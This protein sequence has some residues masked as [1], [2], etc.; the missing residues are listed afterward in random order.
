MI[1]HHAVAPAMAVSCLA[2]LLGCSTHDILTVTDPDVIPTV[3]S[4]SGA[5]ALKNGVILRLEQATNGIQG[6]D[7]LFVYGGLLADEYRSGDT[8][9]Q[10]NDMDQRRFDPTNT[11]LAGPFRALNRIRVEGAAAIQGLR[12]FAPSPQSNIGLMFAL[13]AYSINLAGE[14]YCNGVPLSSLEGTTIVYGDPLPVDSLFALATGFADSALANQPGPDSAR[15]R[16]LASV[17]KG[18]ALL[19]RARYTAAAAAVAGVRDTFHYDVTYSANTSDNQIWALNTS[20]KR[21]F[22]GD[23][24]GGT[25]LPFYS[26]NDPRVIRSKGGKVF[27]SSLPDT[28]ILQGIWGRFSSVPIATGIEARLIEAEASL[29]AGNSGAWLTTLNAL[30]ANTGLYPTAQTGFT[31]APIPL[32]ALADPGTPD[33]RVDLM[34]YERGFWTFSTGHRL[35]DLRRLIRQ[36]GRAPDSVFPTGTYF[37]GGPYGPAVNMPIPLDEQNNPHF[38]Q[39]TNTSA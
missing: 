20:A 31:R 16:Q 28:A 30:R 35:G 10:R 1:R 4:A 23:R 25:G 18:R 39:C 32:A 8:F 24:E 22:I 3:T 15:V 7:A 19:N 21:Y 17:V 13:T 5:I 38:V 2:A 6:P 14:Y 37:K 26:A 33:T 9:V 27:D 12:T 11:F 34:F 36:Y 29:Q